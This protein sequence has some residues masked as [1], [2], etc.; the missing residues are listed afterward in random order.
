MMEEYAKLKSGLSVPRTEE[1]KPTEEKR[2]PMETEY[3]LWI[4]ALVWMREA[5]RTADEILEMIPA[6][7]RGFV[8]FITA[9]VSFLSGLEI[10]YATLVI[11]T[12]LKKHWFAFFALFMVPV[13]IYGKVGATPE[14]F[15]TFCV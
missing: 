11:A 14:W 12:L 4:E 9:M 3:P 13:K 10:L 5:I 1:R 2:R 6:N 8:L 15:E 7:V